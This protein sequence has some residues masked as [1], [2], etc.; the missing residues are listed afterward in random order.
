M[1]ARYAAFYSCHAEAFRLSIR[2]VQSIQTLYQKDHRQV[3]E[4]IERYVRQQRLPPGARL[5]SERTLAKRLGVTHGMVRLANDLLESRGLVR[6]EHGRGTFLS[7]WKP[8]HQRLHRRIGLLIVDRPEDQRGRFYY[9]NL[10]AGIQ[11]AAKRHGYEILLDQMRTEEMLQGKFPRMLLD[12]TVDAVVLDGRTRSHH[13]TY[14]RDQGFLAICTGDTPLGW[15][16]PQIRFNMEQFGQ[17]LVK[18][19]L[20]AGREPVWLDADP[21]NAD[22]FSGQELFRGYAGAMQARPGGGTGLN[23]CL[24]EEETAG[25]VAHL[26]A[27]RGLA[28]AA[29]IT[30]SPHWPLVLEH[31]QKLTPDAGS[32][33]IVPLPMEHLAFPMPNPNCARWTKLLDVNETAALTIERLIELLEG[34]ADAFRSISIE[35]DCR[36]K[37]RSPHLLMD[38]ELRHEDPAHA[39][40]LHQ[41]A[42]GVTWQPHDSEPKRRNT[43]DSI[44]MR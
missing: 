38:L 36:I 8:S 17:S 11:D 15:N 27:A 14:L 16:A 26:L 43:A 34:R 25:Q 4:A 33:W 3:A 35:F 29:L 30:Q 37:E 2:T 18:P 12:R 40:A 13:V 10:V 31:L 6:R 5:P 39:F 32:L 22:Y 19:L 42:N 20:E 28:K 23:L 44:T 24:I 1:E 21:T 41:Y 7:D 9:Q